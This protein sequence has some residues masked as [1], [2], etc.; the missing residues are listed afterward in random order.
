MHRST[1]QPVHDSY[2]LVLPHSREYDDIVTS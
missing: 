1:I 2:N